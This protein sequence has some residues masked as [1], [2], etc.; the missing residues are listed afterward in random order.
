MFIHDFA[1]IVVKK[2]KKKPAYMLDLG[3]AQESKYPYSRHGRSQFKQ[4]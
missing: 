4:T 3:S 1:D 2:K